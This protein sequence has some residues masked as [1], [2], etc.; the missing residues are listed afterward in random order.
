M[1][2]PKYYEDL[3]IVHE[4][5]MPPRAYYIPASKD[6]GP[7]VYDRESSDR[8]QMLNGKWK[9]RYYKS[10]YDLQDKFYEKGY[11]AEGFS[12]VYVPG[13]WQNYGYDRHQYTNIRY[14]IPLEIG[15]AS[16]RER[17]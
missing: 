14:P 15:R 7:L 1:I 5:T 12:E 9:F 3:K 17:V 16:C 8:I 6:M 13:V 11:E 2:V 4:N 10:I